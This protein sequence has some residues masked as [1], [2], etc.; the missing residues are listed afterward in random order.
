MQTFS[1][2]HHQRIARVLAAFNPNVLRQHQCWFGGGTA[3]A[4]RCGEFRES[5]DIDLM[6]SDPQGYRELRHLLTGPEGLQPLTKPGAIPLQV[7]REIRADQY[8][9]RTLLQV[10]DARIK[11]ELV[12]EGRIEFD[13]PGLQDEVCGVPCL[14]WPD[15]V[16]SK[17]LA[18][19]DR[20]ADDGVHSRDLID[21][22]MMEQ[23][24][25]VWQ[26]AL[27]KAE[28]AYGQSIK[29]DLCR[30]IE[31]MQTRDSWLDRCLKALSMTQ[32]K[33]VVWHK[34]RALRRW[35]ENPT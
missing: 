23:P 12:R 8:G 34:V 7:V 3:I 5:V 9:I 19:A 31:R 21:M 27:A 30:A 11:L 18:N 13:A 35:C 24:K 32:P 4:L 20:Y 29:R 16:A 6:V 25:A 26:A 28:A 33:A 2:P 14:S 10:D 17:L 22:A 15:L 1:R